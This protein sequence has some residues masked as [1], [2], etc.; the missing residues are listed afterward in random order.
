MRVVATADAAAVVRE[1]AASGRE[2]LTI[3]VGDGCCDGEAP[4]LYDR[5]VAPPDAERVGDVAGVPVI[6]HARIAR[7]WG[8]DEVELGV[9]RD[10]PNDSFSLESELDCRFTL[11]RPETSE[12][13]AAR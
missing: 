9:D 12:T 13:R 10:V 5:Y 11:G 8:G 6:A 3:V 7:L 2:D 1:V 4:F